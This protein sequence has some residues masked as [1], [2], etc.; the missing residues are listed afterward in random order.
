MTLN[1][2]ARYRNVNVKT[3]KR[4]IKENI[5]PAERDGIKYQIDADLA[6]QVWLEEIDPNATLPERSEIEKQIGAKPIPPT[7]NQESKSYADYRKEK[8]KM[9][10][11]KS[12]T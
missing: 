2:Y 6:D 7:R 4:Y 12:P 5:L 1:E 3:V 8:R 10:L 11:E 9:E